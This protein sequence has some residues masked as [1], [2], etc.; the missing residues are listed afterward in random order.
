MSDNDNGAEFARL[1]RHD[2]WTRQAACRG[3]TTLFFSDSA[4]DQRQARAVCATCPV[5][6]QC[7]Q[8][9]EDEPVRAGGVWAGKS[10]R[11]RRRDRHDAV[12]SGEIKVKPNNVNKPINHGTN[13]GYQ[14]H[15]R[16]GVPMCAPCRQ[17]HN[18]VNTFYKAQV[19]ARRMAALADEVA[20]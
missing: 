20:A 19:A 13:S 6:D 16:Q 11:Q 17:A 15:M 7:A 4:A 10:Q 5:F 9:V 14:T 2:T 1:F 12:A 18:A 8:A 3:L